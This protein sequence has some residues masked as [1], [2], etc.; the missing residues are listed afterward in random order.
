MG[1]L[2]RNFTKECQLEELPF[3]RGKLNVDKMQS[4]GGDREDK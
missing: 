4:T 1:F 3:E 2:S